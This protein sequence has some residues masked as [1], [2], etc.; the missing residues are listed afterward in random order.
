MIHKIINYIK[1]YGIIALIKKS[2]R[3]I[4]FINSHTIW[5][6]DLNELIVPLP[7]NNTYSVYKANKDEIDLIVSSWPRELGNQKSEK[8][9]TL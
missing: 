3:M 5:Y 6:R 1:N 2:L 8:I 7:K 4:Y 9:K